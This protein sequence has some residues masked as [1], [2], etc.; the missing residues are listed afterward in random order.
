MNITGDPSFI[1]TK[2][3]VSKKIGE[4]KKRKTHAKTTSKIRLT[5]LSYI[6]LFFLIFILIFLR[7]F[8]RKL[9]RTEDLLLF[10]VYDPCLVIG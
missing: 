9:Q 4:S 6:F 2:I 8:K 7:K 1:L 10:G 3:A 5:H